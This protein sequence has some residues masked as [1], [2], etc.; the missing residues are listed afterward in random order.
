MRKIILTV[1]LE[2]DWGGRSGSLY[3]IEVGMC[4][5][6]RLLKANEA[7]AT[8]FVS[9]SIAKKIKGLLG[10]IIREDHE[11]ASHGYSH[12]TA[13]DSMKPDQLMMEI[14]DSKKCLEDIISNSVIGFRTPQ[15]RKHKDTDRFLLESGYVYDS[16]CVGVAM[17]GRYESMQNCSKEILQIPV[18]SLLGLLP[19]GLKW[20]NLARGFPLRKDRSVIY[21]HMFDLLSAWETM[22]NFDHYGL[23]VLAFYLARIG[24]PWNTL[25]S[26]SYGSISIKKSIYSEKESDNNE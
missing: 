2:S 21:M 24:S 4:R 9:G 19:A 22:Q 6:L 5:L 13:Y 11:I 10:E 23:K 20:I 7:T 16:S 14:V 25:A 3:S 18:S 12:N 26:C 1:D 8:F 15:F 17:P